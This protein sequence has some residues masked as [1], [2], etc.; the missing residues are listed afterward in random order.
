MR[1]VLNV[2]RM[3]MEL[4]CRTAG[5]P[6]R[7]RQTYPGRV[8]LGRDRVALD[9]LRAQRR[10]DSGPA[11]AARRARPAR[12][13]WRSTSKKRAQR[14]ARVAAAEAVGAER[15]EA[16]RARTRRSAADRRAR[17]RSRRRPARRRAGS[18]CDVARARRLPRVQPVPALDVARLAREL[19]E[20]G[21][22]P[23]LGCRRPSRAPAARP[24]AITSRRIVPEPSSR[25]VPRGP[26]RLV[27]GEAVHAA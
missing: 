16:A 21:H 27:H 19:A 4:T 17:S 3:L 14:G 6:C 2:T 1:W 9:R 13:W 11:A 5:S 10:V 22:A 7:R 20:A 25:T 18:R 26:A 15:D 24:A 12:S 23:D 8:A